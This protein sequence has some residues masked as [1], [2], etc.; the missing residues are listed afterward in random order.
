MLPNYITFLNIS[1][2]DYEFVEPSD[3]IRYTP[4][5]GL[6]QKI[7]SRFDFEPPDPQCHVQEACMGGLTP[8]VV[9]V[10]ILRGL[11]PL[12]VFTLLNHRIFF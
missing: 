9:A 8:T 7:G 10:V 11:T 3:C 2:V 6:N 12:Q 1:D 4:L 5:G